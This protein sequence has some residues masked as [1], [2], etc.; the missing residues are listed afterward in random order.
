MIVNS[1]VWTAFDLFFWL[2]MAYI[3]I[4]SNNRKKYVI[5]EGRTSFDEYDSFVRDKGEE[6]EK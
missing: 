4:I 3:N 2:K 1:F 6:Y 5:I